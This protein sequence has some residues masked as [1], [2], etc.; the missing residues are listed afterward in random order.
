MKY[1]IAVA[2]LLLGIAGLNAQNSFSY[3]S[4]RKFYSPDDLIGYNFK[5]Y[6]LEIKDDREENLTPDVYSF[7]VTQSNLYVSGKDIE[8]VYS[9]N[10]INSTNYGFQL[11]LMNARNPTLQGHLKIIVNK[12]KQVEALV[13]K[14]SAKEKEIIFH[15]AKLNEAQRDKEMAYFT[16]RGEMV[17]PDPDSLYGKSIFPM[18]AMFYD[19]GTQDK[20]AYTDSIY[21]KFEKKTT[22]IEKIIK[23]KKKKTKPEKVKEAKP[24][25]E[26]IEK[27]KKEKKKKKKKEE[28]EDEDAVVNDSMKDVIEGD[29][30]ETEQTEEEVKA[31]EQ[32]AEEEEEAEEEKE[33]P[34]AEVVEISDDEEEEVPEEP[35]KKITI[36]EENFATVRFLVRYQ[37]GREEKEE[38][39]YK[40]NKLTQKED[41]SA[42]ADDEKFQITVTPVSGAPFYIYLNADK[43]V[44]SVEFKDR[45]LFVR[46][47]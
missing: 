31:K 11:L 1:C 3:M 41:K 27:P 9:I 43:S 38:K 14:R 29:A 4:D 37:D 20:F 46:G 2:F 39:V 5:P 28:E 16:D 25:P 24:K 44:N 18:T 33:E 34:K 30:E 10:N 36:I 40:I 13:F 8:G 19:S 32:P 47:Y 17:I 21:L 7:G 35:K 26:K 22:I 23:E 6:R 12:A 42:E 45:K 15:I